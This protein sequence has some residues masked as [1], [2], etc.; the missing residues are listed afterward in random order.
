MNELDGLTPEQ[1]DQI[2]RILCGYIWWTGPDGFRLR[3]SAGYSKR[4]RQ[5]IYLLR[6]PETAPLGQAH[7]IGRDPQVIRR[8]FNTEREAIQ[9]A[10]YEA[11]RFDAVRWTDFPG[12][13]DS[14]LYVAYAGPS[15]LR[16]GY[17]WG[18]GWT[19]QHET[20]RHTYGGPA[21]S[22]EDAKAHA[23]NHYRLY[24]HEQEE[25]K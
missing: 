6:L 18:G 10:Q 5:A 8:R 22:L 11:G 20:A 9:W 23:F 25:T 7:R 1:A 24:A 13:D 2:D 4:D 14:A 15:T 21:A 16:A 19:W 17:T 12:L 3:R